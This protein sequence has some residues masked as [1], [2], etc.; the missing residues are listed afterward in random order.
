[1]IERGKGN[2]LAGVEGL[3]FGRWPIAERL[4]QL[5]VVEPADV[6]DDGQLELGAGAPNAVGDE[7]VLKLSTKL[8]AMALSPTEPIEPSMR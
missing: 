5:L 1:L 6:F 2:P 3:R 8:S 7:L 4:V